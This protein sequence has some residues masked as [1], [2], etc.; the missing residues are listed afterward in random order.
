MDLA[1]EAYLL[2]YYLL[3]DGPDLLRHC[4]YRWG[5]IGGHLCWCFSGIICHFICV[6]NGISWF[7][8]FALHAWFF[9]SPPPVFFCSISS[10]KSF[11]GHYIIFIVALFVIFYV[12]SL[13]VIAKHVI[14]SR[15]FKIV[16][17]LVNVTQR[18]AIGRNSGLNLNNAAWGNIALFFLPI[19]KNC[20]MDYL[21]RMP[22]EKAYLFWWR[23]SK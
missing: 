5:G 19:L 22:A 23:I 17:F 2:A 12:F 20:E 9:R 4:F 10:F 1:C 8:S 13:Y 11:L 16:L 14:N 7:V 15:L 21:T 18:F 3:L 6:L